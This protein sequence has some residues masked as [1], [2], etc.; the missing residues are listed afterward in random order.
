M[1]NQ[2]LKNKIA[3]IWQQDVLAQCNDIISFKY[4]FEKSSKTDASLVDLQTL[5][6]TSG[7][8]H[9]FFVEHL[10]PLIK[11]KAY[12]W[13][14]KDNVAET[15]GF[16]PE[17]LPFFEQQSRVRDSLFV[18]DGNRAQLDFSLKPIFLDSRLAKFKM[19]IHGQ[20]MSYQFGRPITTNV[21]WPPENFSAN[22]QFNFI[23][24]DGSEVV[25]IRN[26]LFAFFRLLD[27][28]DINQVNRNKVEVTFSKNNFKAIYELS[29]KGKVNPVIFSQLAN[30]KCL[31]AL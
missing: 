8:I 30:F 2:L 25:E 14:W 13:Q 21:S 28:S 6:G 9:Q 7:A 3:K 16:S 23:R 12:P 15:H 5:F 26:G 29:G 1:R 24:R 17:V 31:A 18:I 10:Q 27:A 22:S 20:N 19:S 11:S 4:P